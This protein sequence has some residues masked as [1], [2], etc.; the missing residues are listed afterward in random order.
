IGIPYSRLRSIANFGFLNVATRIFAEYSSVTSRDASRGST[1]SS[2]SPYWRNRRVRW[3]ITRVR[4]L[5]LLI[6]ISEN[7]RKR[8]RTQPPQQAPSSFFEQLQF[9]PQF[10]SCS[11]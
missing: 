5:S 9:A 7:A 8:G 3:Y 6:L 1:I 4:R 11:F 10:P 2:S